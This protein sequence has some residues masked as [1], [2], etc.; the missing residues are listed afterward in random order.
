[1]IAIRQ[2]LPVGLFAAAIFSSI[3]A[4]YCLPASVKVMHSR[5]IGMWTDKWGH[6]LTRGI[7]NQMESSYF[8]GPQ[9]YLLL[10][11]RPTGGV[12]RN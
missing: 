9:Q 3:P 4:T 11:V 8:H 6:W 5:R 7:A 10:E 1:M 2:R 12:S